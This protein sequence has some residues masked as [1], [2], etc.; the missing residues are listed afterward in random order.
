MTDHFE[1]L[2]LNEFSI[3]FFRFIHNHNKNIMY[4]VFVSRFAFMQSRYNIY[5]G[6]V[7]VLY[8]NKLFLINQCSLVSYG[9]SYRKRK[10]KSFYLILKLHIMALKAFLP[11]FL[12]AFVF[13][14]VYNVYYIQYTIHIVAIC[15]I[16]NQ[17][18]NWWYSFLIFLIH[19]YNIVYV[20][21]K[22]ECELNTSQ[23]KIYFVH[24]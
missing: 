9:K 20:A 15:N 19:V 3:F 22:C 6:I 10:K 5:L 13:C 2:E 18:M 4:F 8:T 17:H 11:S 7:A 24:V 12:L 14:V 23:G 16:Y 21:Y 1:T